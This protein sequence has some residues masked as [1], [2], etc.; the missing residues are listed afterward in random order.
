MLWN[1]WGKYE[2]IYFLI[3]IIL[4]DCG[5]QNVCDILIEGMRTKKMPFLFSQKKP[6]NFVL[7][8]CVLEFKNIHKY[9]QDGNAK[10]DAK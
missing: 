8:L 5:E 2:L 10:D 6:R 1:K 4:I 3:L 9:I 7:F